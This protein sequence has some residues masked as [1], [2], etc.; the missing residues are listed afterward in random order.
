ASLVVGFTVFFLAGLAVGIGWTAWKYPGRPH[1]AGD[2]RPVQVTVTRGMAV[3]DIGQILA[4]RDVL[5]HPRW[6][7]IY[8]TERRDSVK[9]RPGR[10]T[11]NASMTPRQI[12][13]SLVTGVAEEE[14]EV[15]IPEGK[16]LLEIA[17]ILDEAG[18]CKAAEFVHAVRDPQ[19]LRQLALAADT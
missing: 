6:F 10:F 5:D 14:V 16:T 8:A 19:L 11:F 2:A 13:D 3:S 15:V 9:V 1:R 18:V 7:S 4:E 17:A 12:M